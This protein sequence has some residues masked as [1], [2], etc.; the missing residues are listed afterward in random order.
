MR[1]LRD[2]AK[3]AWKLD[4]VERGIVDHALPPGGAVIV[5]PDRYVASVAPAN[6]EL[7]DAMNAN[8]INGSGNRGILATRHLARRVVRVRRFVVGRRNDVLHCPQFLGARCVGRLHG[9]TIS[10]QCMRHNV[11]Q[12]ITLTR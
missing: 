2:A 5:R 8:Q 11:T 12:M 1:A 4:R 9:P 6:N 10:C 3:L 7:A